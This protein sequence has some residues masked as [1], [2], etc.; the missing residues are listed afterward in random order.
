MDNRD[1]A[2]LE[3]L[4]SNDGIGDSCFIFETEKNE[5]LGSTGTLPRDYSAGYPNTSSIRQGMEF[6]GRANALFLQ[7]VAMVS[8]GMGTHG[9]SRGIKV[10]NESFFRGHGRQRRV[11]G[12]GVVDCFPRIRR[13]FQAFEQR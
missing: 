4:R 6:D 5:T 1:V 10:G 11:R 9:N 2:T 13:F 12:R 7:F 3:K 8:H